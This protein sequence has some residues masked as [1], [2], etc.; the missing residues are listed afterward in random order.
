MLTSTRGHA[1]TMRQPS[2]TPLAQFDVY[3]VV[4]LRQPRGMPYYSHV[5]SCRRYMMR[6]HGHARFI[7][8]Y[9]P[10]RGQR[11]LTA[12]CIFCSLRNQSPVSL[13]WKGFWLFVHCKWSKQ[14]FARGPG[15]KRIVPHTG[16]V[17]MWTTNVIQ[18]IKATPLSYKV[19]R[20][21]NTTV[22]FPTFFILHDESKYLEVQHS[23]RYKIKT[24]GCWPRALYGFTFKCKFQAFIFS[25]FPCVTWS[26]L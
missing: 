5:H 13:C 1:W 3:I 24:E 19:L 6:S 22:F 18:V 25:V 8:V 23:K 16:A 4:V 14:P 17:R 10:E 26:V 2:S 20:T 7:Q 11:A 21:L 15:L 12:E 9:S